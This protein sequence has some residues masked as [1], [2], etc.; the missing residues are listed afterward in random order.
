MER[1]FLQEKGE[2]F[3]L[4]DKISLAIGYYGGRPRAACTVVD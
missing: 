3:S 2:E 4:T 1:Y